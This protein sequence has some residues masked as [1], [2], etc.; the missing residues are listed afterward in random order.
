M[1]MGFSKEYVV[2]SSNFNI[3]SLIWLEKHVLQDE[4]KL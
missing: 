4:E 2:W 3:Q 1:E